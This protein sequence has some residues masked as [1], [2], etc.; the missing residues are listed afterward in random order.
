MHNLIWNN[1]I[2]KEE[3]QRR[4]EM[5]E[6]LE[7]AKEAEK[8]AAEQKDQNVKMA[9]RKALVD[10]GF[11]TEKEFEDAERRA[12]VKM[13]KEREEEEAKKRDNEL[14]LDA[15]KKTVDN[16]VFAAADK[17]TPKDAFNE[18]R[19]VG[20]LLFWRAIEGEDE[21]IDTV[22]TLSSHRSL[23]LECL[24]PRLCQTA[25]KQENPVV[26]LS[27]VGGI[28]RAYRK[29]AKKIPQ[30]PPIADSHPEGRRFL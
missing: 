16:L 8:K 25:W 27:L 30:D 13:E 19:R 24:L 11:M 6:N 21:C 29:L 3:E 18:G 5:P 2:V 4:A 28:E 20:R 12:R 7:I 15:A 1:Q 9:F 10:T 22:D 17:K 14:K 23:I 26:G